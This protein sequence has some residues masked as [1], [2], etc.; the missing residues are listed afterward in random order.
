MAQ[1]SH[2]K[3]AHVIQGLHIAGSGVFPVVRANCFFGQEIVGNVADVVT[4]VGGGIL[5]A[6]PLGVARFKAAGAQLGARG[7]RTNLH[8]GVVIVKLAVH[9]PALGLEQVANGVAQCGLTAM[10]H[11]Q[12][13]GR[14][15]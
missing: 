4:V 7:Q 12:R 1:V 13:S 2:G 10:T 3:Q 15:G 9:I 14:I 8:A 5:A 11:V 6:G